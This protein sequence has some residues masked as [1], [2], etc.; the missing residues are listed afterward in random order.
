MQVNTAS[1]LGSKAPY[2]QEV[3][4]SVKEP[5]VGPHSFRKDQRGFF[6]GREEEAE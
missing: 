6:F 4:E 2:L 3:R 1:S 5:Y